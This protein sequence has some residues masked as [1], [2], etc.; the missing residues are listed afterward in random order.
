MFSQYCSFIRR[1]FNHW[2]MFTSQKRCKGLP[3]PKKRN[4]GSSLNARM[5]KCPFHRLLL[6]NLKLLC[7]WRIQWQKQIKLSWEVHCKR[8]QMAT[9]E[10]NER[11]KA[12]PICLFNEWRIYL[13]LWRVPRVNWTR[14]QRFY[15]ML[16]N[17]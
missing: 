1:N 4:D 7:N 17:R 2:W 6:K 14:N 10:W 9:N 13:H 16:R 5:Q 15:R 3:H 11:Q 8:R 12:L